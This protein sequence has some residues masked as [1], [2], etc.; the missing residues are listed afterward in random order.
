VRAT[1]SS[2][3]AILAALEA[4]YRLGAVLQQFSLDGFPTAKAKAVSEWSEYLRVRHIM[5]RTSMYTRILIRLDSSKTALVSWRESSDSRRAARDH[6]HCGNSR[7]SRPE[8]PSAR[9]PPHRPSAESKAIRHFIDSL[10]RD[11]IRG[12]QNQGSRCGEGPT[13]P[14]V[15]KAY[16]LRIRVLSGRSEQLACRPS[17]RFYPLVQAIPQP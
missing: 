15:F 17:L 7:T 16:P 14:L 3:I 8:S 9:A 12:C 2:R 1:G 13:R 11:R 5:R 6:R 4:K 10:H